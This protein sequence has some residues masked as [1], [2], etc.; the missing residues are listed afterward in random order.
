M[1]PHDDYLWSKAGQGEDDIRRLER[2]LAP[3]AHPRGQRPEVAPAMPASMPTPHRRRPRRLRIA[4]GLAATLAACA[5]AAALLLQHR[6]AWPEHRGWDVAATRGQ[7][8]V[9]GAPLRAGERL[10]A[11]GEI[12]TGDD[13]SARLRIARIGELRLD[14][15][16]R[17]RLEQTGSGRHR[18]R[19]LQGRLW[20][21]VWAPPGYFGVR[22][23][24]TEALDMGCE[25]TL[26]S[27]ATGAG[28]LTVRSGWVLVGNGGGEVLVPQGATVRLRADGAAGTP[29]DLGASAGFV[30]ALAEL[31]A[32]RGALPADDEGVGRLLAQA[33]PQDAISLLSLL[34][35]QPSLAGG[36]LYDRLRAFLANAP[37]P[38]REAVLRGAPGAL[39]PW[40]N[41]LPYPRAK[42]WWLQWPD[43]LPAGADAAAVDA[44]VGKGA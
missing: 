33:R 3:Y 44:R 16:S 21:R 26:E 41:A 20:A 7:V 24:R 4:W 11:G 17:L 2:L 1:N 13:G 29:Y 36:P 40:W 12:A 32:Q 39:D 35:R 23:P 22:L 9:A 25:F 6:L 28:A 30:A 43:A 34:Q 38:S 37:A 18:V 42:R 5:L 14:A 31:D 19:L 27:D 10:P 15:G 8:R